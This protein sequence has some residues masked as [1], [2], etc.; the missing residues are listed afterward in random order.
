MFGPVVPGAGGQFALVDALNAEWAEWNGEGWSAT[1]C[2]TRLASWSAQEPVLAG[3]GCLADVLEAIRR[4]PDPMLASLIRLHQG[5][6]AMGGGRG[7]RRPGNAGPA[8][9]ADRQLAGRIV[10]QTML[11]K[12]V[13]MTR[14]DRQH[15][16]ED[17]VAAFWVRMSKYPLERRPVRIAANLALDT[18]KDTTRDRARLQLVPYGSDLSALSDMTAA[19]AT[20][21]TT[22]RVLRAARD[23]GLIDEDTR[24]LLSRVYTD[25]LSSRQAAETFGLTPTTVRYRCSRAVRKLA[26]H[27]Q[28]LAIA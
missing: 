26:R 1:R 23:S 20:P 9:G 25:G 28:G 4:D 16:V 2:A 27:A 6:H 17:Y 13:L 15:G 21:T 7:V 10:L 11:G 12:L 5:Y 19:T 22:A 8:I 14:R 3:C 24:H 18:L